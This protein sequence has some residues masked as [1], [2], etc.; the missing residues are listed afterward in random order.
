MVFNLYKLHNLIIIYNDN[1]KI[2][3][4]KIN[5]FKN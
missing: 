1:L 4:L 3:N 5:N 2:D